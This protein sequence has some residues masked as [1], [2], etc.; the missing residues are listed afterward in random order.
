MED[1]GDEAKKALDR[2]VVAVEYRCQLE[3]L[4]K[5]EAIARSGLIS[6]RMNYQPF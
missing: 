4:H 1:K 6:D 3:L 2:I 5:V